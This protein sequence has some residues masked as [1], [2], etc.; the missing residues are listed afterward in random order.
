MMNDFEEKKTL[1]YIANGL[2]NKK[3]VKIN[4]EKIAEWIIDDGQKF[5]EHIYTRAVRCIAEEMLSQHIPT[6]ELSELDFNERCEKA[7]RL[8]MYNDF[9]EVL[10]L[11]C[12]QLYNKDY[13]F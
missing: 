2:S 3:F 10:M 7:F 11:I 5:C 1:L 13:Q 8:D 4:V 9:E 6:C 12:R